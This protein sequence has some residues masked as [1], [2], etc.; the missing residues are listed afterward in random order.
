[1]NFQFPLVIKDFSSFCASCIPRFLLF[2]LSS[3]LGCT[4]M[5]TI[6]AAAPLMRPTTPTKPNKISSVH[7]EFLSELFLKLI[8]LL[9][10]QE[11]RR[12]RREISTS[13]SIA[14]LFVS[15]KMLLFTHIFLVITCRNVWN[16]QRYKNNLSSVSMKIFLHFFSFL[17]WQK[18]S[19]R[20]TVENGKEKSCRVEYFS[21]RL[22]Q[23][24][25]VLYE[26]VHWASFPGKEFMKVFP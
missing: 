6:C 8:Y 4:L 9:H 13:L 23:H 19:H 21:C 18:G 7:L 11:S 12:R 5:Y 25:G 3:R 2:R 15:L 17:I 22:Q 20:T 26:L 1:M 16:W 24:W 14:S 10:T